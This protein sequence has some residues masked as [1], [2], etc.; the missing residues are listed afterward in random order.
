MDS[1][2]DPSITASYKSL[3]KELAHESPLPDDISADF[4]WTNE[5]RWVANGPVTDKELEKLAKRVRSIPQ[6]EMIGAEISADGMKSLTN[7]GVRSIRLE[8]MEMNPQFAD[9]LSTYRDLEILEL[10]D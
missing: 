4:R 9:V 10:R 1:K 7:R 2:E 5:G 3:N 6:I 8:Y